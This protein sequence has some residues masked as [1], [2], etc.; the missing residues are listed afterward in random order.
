MADVTGWLPH[1]HHLADVYKYL[2]RHIFLHGKI[3]V[4][5]LGFCCSVSLLSS[6][7]KNQESESQYHWNPSKNLS[8]FH[9]AS[10]SNASM[11]YL[12]LERIKLILI[13]FPC[14]CFGAFY[15]YCWNCLELGSEKAVM[16]CMF[17]QSPLANLARL[18]ME[19]GGQLYLP[20][21]RQKTGGETKSHILFYPNI[22]TAAL[23]LPKHCRETDTLNVP[24][25]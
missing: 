23:Q 7:L 4:Q 21:R 10:K 15:I 11:L 17:L 24:G 6:G 20:S 16:W 2:L 22:G 5:N 18:S 14:V 9:P 8:G 25:E 19:P 3:L 13:S 1:T 12:S